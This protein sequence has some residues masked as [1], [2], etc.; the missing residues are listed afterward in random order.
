MEKKY[1][2]NERNVQ[3]LISLLKQYGIKKVIASPGTTNMTF[4]GSIQH[5]P[6]FEIYSSVDERSAAYIACGL[7]C[8]SNEPVVLTCTGAT[9]SRNYLPGLTEAYYRKL[10]ILAVT[11]HRGNH[12]IGHLIDQQIDRRQRPNDVAVES[13]ELPLCKSASDESYCINEAN[14]ALLA[15]TL[16]GGGPVHINM[17]TGYSSDFS[18]KELPQAR[19]ISRITPFDIMPQLPQ[20]GRIGIFVGAHRDFSLRE[21]KAIEGFCATN[22]AVV[23]CDHTSGYCGKYAVQMELLCCQQKYSSYNVDV[24]L[25]IHIGEV[26]GCY[27]PHGKCIWRI[28]E[29]G[30]LRNTFGSLQYIFMMPEYAFFEHYTI[31][32]ESHTDFLN[33]CQQEYARAVKSIP[34]L[35]FGNAWIAQNYCNRIPENVQIHFGIY[36]SLRSW[37]FFKLPE[38]VYG[39]CNVGGFGIDGGVSTLIG[40]S[41]A[42]R[43]KLHFGVFGD[44]AFFYDMNALGN[45]HI[46]NNLRILLINNNKG[47]EFRLYGHPCFQFGEEADTYMAAAGH[48]GK[49]SSELVRHYATDLGFE[50][51]TASDKES[52]DKVAETFFNPLLTD[53]SILLEV[54]TNSDSESEALKLLQHTLIDKERVIKNRVKGIIR[55]V[56]PSSLLKFVHKII[57]KRFI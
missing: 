1:Y 50:Y 54:F 40:A 57:F 16:N 48:Y 12:A 39:K 33:S 29:D 53:K 27:Y 51:L 38:G 44:L 26:S 19:K 34:D 23:Y 49:G 6:W 5:D 35:P 32:G 45:R 46:G 24:E 31:E 11:S 4:V 52:F 41:L 36:N 47:G 21:V 20:Q 2:T 3:I 8:E 22:D 15:L 30:A 28:S 17:F 14:K 18:V 10:P 42:N 56:V 43:E 7:S 13:I 25:M 9:A 55:K 37:N